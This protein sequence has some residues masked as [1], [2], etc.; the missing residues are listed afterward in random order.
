MRTVQRGLHDQSFSVNELVGMSFQDVL[1]NFMV[2]LLFVMVLGGSAFVSSRAARSAAGM[3][4]AG[5][6]LAIWVDRQGQ[7]GYYR[8]PW[9]A[10][11]VRPPN[12][13]R[14]PGILSIPW[15]S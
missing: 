11:S 9:R 10:W 5:S 1:T 14:L 4:P 2:L 12:L 13:H 15:P 3:P 8:F 6:S 7:T